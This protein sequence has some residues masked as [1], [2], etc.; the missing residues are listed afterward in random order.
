M[1]NLLDKLLI[2]LTCKMNT[3]I[4]EEAGDTNFISI[5]VILG[6]VMVLVGI[7]AVFKDQ[8]IEAASNLI[9]NNLNAI[10]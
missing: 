5:I 1:R 3:L 6:I 7:F 10:H 4:E 2:K 8:I 9:N